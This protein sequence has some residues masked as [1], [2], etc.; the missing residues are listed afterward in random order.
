[1]FFLLLSPL[2]TDINAIQLGPV[3]KQ[4]EDKQTQVHFAKGRQITD[5]LRMKRGQLAAFADEGLFFG[6]KPSPKE[7]IE[8]KPGFPSCSETISKQLSLTY[9]TI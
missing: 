3:S 2:F 1:M 8:T 6:G 4:H 9:I 7:N 5:E